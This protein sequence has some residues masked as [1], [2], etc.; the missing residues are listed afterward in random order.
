MAYTDIQP[1]LNNGFKYIDQ[2]MKLFN[3]QKRNYQMKAMRWCITK[4]LGYHATYDSAGNIM[5]KLTPTA[6]RGII[7]D[8]MGL[9]KTI[10]MLGT[11]VGNFKKNTLIVL[12]SAL[13]HQWEK[14]IKK[15]LGC[16]PLVFH[17]RNSRMSV[18]KLKRN[19]I[20]LTTY[21]MI[22]TRPNKKKWTSK[23]W[24]IHWDRVIFDEAHHLRNKMSNKHKGAAK[25]NGDIMWFM[26]GTPIQN[27]GKDLISLCKLM[28]I[29]DEML[30]NSK[31]T[32]NILRRY[33]MMRS[34]KQVGIDME[35]VENITINIDIFDSPEEKK[36]IHDLHSMLSFTNVSVEN[37]D[38]A[39]AY[40]GGDSPL[41]L[42]V[43]ARQVCV[44]PTILSKHLKKMLHAGEIPSDITWSPCKT[45]TKM[46][47]ISEKS[48]EIRK[49]GRILIFC[50][51]MQ[52]M[53][54][55]KKMLNEK[56][57]TVKMMNGKTT[58]KER[59]FI[60]LPYIKDDDW[61]KIF[62]MQSTYQVEP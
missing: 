44:A 41:P 62:S 4:E 6:K 30:K 14:L 45:N 15:F 3:I 38:A 23:L 10:V 42:L 53:N 51:Y 59:K 32:I 58:M 2:W 37:V 18:D 25:L 34:K 22:S 27:S 43:R 8:E 11:W 55:L 19:N 17:G 46:R 36:L 26:T 47:M 56:G 48:K 49:D 39:I 29:Y 33:V 52:E 24:D 21:G 16:S 7:A 13:L 50:H 9:G 40:L 35:P 31:E 1:M 28:G 12:P 57:L 60:G 5:G 61:T 20:V 54:L